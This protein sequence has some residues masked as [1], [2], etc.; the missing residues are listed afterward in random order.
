MRVEITSLVIDISLK[1]AK[2][3][4]CV[5]YIS[6]LPFSYDT[7]HLL[8]NLLTSLRR[9]NIGESCSGGHCLSPGMPTHYNII[10]RITDMGLRCKM[11]VH[12]ILEG[13]DTVF[14]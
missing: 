1:M 5:L 10:R 4:L 6:F 7:E 13:W 8:S 14:E 3:P 9:S 11:R 12:R 2:K